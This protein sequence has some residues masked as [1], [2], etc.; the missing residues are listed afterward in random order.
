MKLTYHQ[1][2]LQGT[3]FFDRKKNQNFKIVAIKS[4]HTTNHVRAIYLKA[5]DGSTQQFTDIF[6]EKLLLSGEIEIKS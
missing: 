1:H 5:K 2:R 3:L 6:L 4:D